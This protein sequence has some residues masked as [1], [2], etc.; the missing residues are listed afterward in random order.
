[1]R[2]RASS[3]PAWPLRSARSGLRPLAGRGSGLTF[4]SWPCWPPAG[5]AGTL[6]FEEKE[7][8]GQIGYLIALIA[9]TRPEWQI[10]VA[11]TDLAGHTEFLKE[12]VLALLAAQFPDT[13]FRMDPSREAGRGYYV[14]ACYKVFAINASLERR[15][16]CDGGCTTWTR[17]LLSDDKE[18]LVIAGLGLERL[19]A[20]TR[21]ASPGEA[22]SGR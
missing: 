18:R 17:Q 11:V 15:E 14:D 12:R 8:R 22:G 7:L 13:A 21:R 6:V 2:G 20:W 5:L 1:M 10:D 3:W 16:L 4:A 9:A 19:L